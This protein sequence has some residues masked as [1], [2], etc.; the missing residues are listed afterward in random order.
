MRFNGKRKSDARSI[1]WLFVLPAL[2]TGGQ[3]GRRFSPAK[4]T[5]T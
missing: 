1:C 2:S 5:I 4:A 3:V